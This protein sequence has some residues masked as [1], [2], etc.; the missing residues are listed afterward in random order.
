MRSSIAIVIV[1]SA[2]GSAAQPAQRQP[3]PDALSQA[4][5]EKTI[6][7]IFA[8][9]YAMKKPTDQVELARKLLRVAEETADDPVGQYVMLREACAL[10]ARNGSIDL[11]SA[12]AAVWVKRFAI[13]PSSAKLHLLKAIDLAPVTPAIAKS[14]FELATV[15]TDE[16]VQED[17]Y[18]RAAE[19]LK[20][21]EGFLLRA[22]EAE[23]KAILAARAEEVDM[24]RQEFVRIKPAL[25]KLAAMPENAD[26]CESAGRF[27][28]FFKGNWTRGLP[29]LAKAKDEALKQLA[30]KDVGSPMEA[31]DRLSLAEAWWKFGDPLPNPQRAE[32]R[33]R[34]GMWYKQA[35]PGLA[36][37]TKLRVDKRIAEID[38]LA[39][40]RMISARRSG[41]VDGKSEIAVV[42]DA[43]PTNVP[44]AFQCRLRPNRAKLLDEGGGTSDSEAAVA[45]GLLWLARVQSADGRW[46]LDGN[47]PDKGLANDAA[48]AALGVLPFLATGFTHRAAKDNP[49]ERPVDKAI[50]YL[51]GIQDKKTGA[52]TR[53]MYAHALCTMAI[54]EAFALSQ[55]F[56]LKKPAQKAIDFIVGAQ[57]SAGGWRYQ[58]GQA[59]DTS[60]TV[61]QIM[62]LK[63]GLTAGLDVPAGT[64]RKAQNYLDGVLEANT[65]GYGYIN[66]TPTPTMSAVSLLCRQYLQG[67]GPQNLR[68]IK[69][70]DNYIKP[71]YPKIDRKD[72]YYY[73]YATQVMHRFG[74]L[75]WKAWN[76]KMRDL[77]V[78]SQDKDNAN[79]ATLGSWSPA[80]DT[81]GRTGG[82]LM[83]TSLSLLSLEVYYRYP[84]SDATDRK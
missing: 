57:H 25:E 5:A 67:W 9:D 62:A 2:L 28:C 3:I 38:A 23:H 52:F 33:L 65:E 22:K 40:V 21:S 68:M 31:S 76:T 35:S 49:Y 79:L 30:V 66:P 19:I 6:K 82:R 44:A 36:G 72:I 51:V 84:M 16:A 15:A 11:A 59:G 18:P 69:G 73:Y 70:I 13:S 78:N 26:L 71:N 7:E 64:L 47:F 29:L 58:P 42:S 1:A 63:S 43:S 80:G 56:A 54:C 34:A 17:E 48:G 55:D 27:F 75:D 45:K 60:V 32:V 53:D 37:L 77:L 50:K 10:A 74:G 24:I 4:K 39:A 46:K 14:V 81:W 41:S 61:W 8:A 83:Q 12:A 20:L